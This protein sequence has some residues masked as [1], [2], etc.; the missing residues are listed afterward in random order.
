MANHPNILKIYET[1]QNEF[2]YVIITEF[3]KGL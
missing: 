3:I 1:I 2:N